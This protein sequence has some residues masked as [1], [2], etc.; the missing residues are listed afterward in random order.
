MRRFELVEGASNKFWEV[1][2]SGNDVTTHWGRIGTAG[3]SKTKTFASPA[4]AQKEHDD[5]VREK[6]AKGYHETGV[7][8][9]A[10]APV[11]KVP[12]PEPAA[13]PPPPP[14]PPEPKSDETIPRGELAR[15][16][17]PFRGFG[18]KRPDV[19]VAAAFERMRAHYRDH[20]TLWE[21]AAG[22]DPA[23]T[24]LLTRVREQLSGSSPALGTLEEETA[25]A[26]VLAFRQHWNLRPVDDDVIDRWVALGGIAFAVEAA[27]AAQ[28]LFAT[29]PPLRLERTFEP[30]LRDGYAHY[31]TRGTLGPLYRLRRHLASAPEPEWT[32]ARELARNARAAAPLSVRVAID[33]LFPEA[34]EWA[35]EDAAEVFAQGSDQRWRCALLMTGVDP[36]IA[37]RLIDSIGHPYNTIVCTTS[38]YGDVEGTAWSLVAAHGA[39]AAPALVKLFDKASDTSEWRRDI[40]A[41]LA[42]LPSDEALV[43]LASRL[44]LREVIPAATEAAHRFPR[45]AIPLLASLAGRGKPLVDTILSGV[46]A[47]NEAVV[48]ELLP[49]LSDSARALVENLRAKSATPAVEA[50]VDDLP[51]VL[52]NPPWKEKRK[53]AAESKPLQ[54][55]TF[56]VPV[57]VLWPPGLREEWSGGRS[58][59]DY[60]FTHHPAIDASVLERNGLTAVDASAVA[61]LDDAA[62]RAR[63]A[64]V[65]AA[66]QHSAYSQFY[67]SSLVYAS[68]K[69]ALAMWDAIPAERWSD[70]DPPTK[71]LLKFEARAFPTLLRYVAASP[72]KRLELLIPFRSPV[73]APLVADALAR[74]KSARAVAR[75]WL[76]L[77]P[78][79]AAIGLIPPAAGARGAARDA[80]ASALRFLTANG[81]EETV[82]STAARYGAEAAAAV[83]EA[84]DFDP[85]LLYP[86][87]LPKLPPFWHQGAFTR[88]LLRGNGAALPASAMETLATMLAFS[89]LGEPYAGLAE[90]KEACKPASLGAFAW[91]L[92]SA[93]LVAGAPSK[94]SW[95]FNAVGLLG[96]DACARRLAPLI[97]EWPGEAAHARAVAGLDVLA[98]IGSDVALMHLNGIAQKVKF[99]GLQEKAREKIEELAERRGLTAE[100]LADRLVP[101]LGLEPDGSMTLDFGPRSFRVGFDEHLRPYVKD[102]QGKKLPDLPKPGKS[103]DAEKGKQATERWKALK[104]DVKTLAGQQILRLETA[105][106]SRR[107]F[108]AAVFRQFFVEHPLVQHLVRRIVW[109]AYD[110]QGELLATF[111]VSEDRTFA[112]A[113]DDAYQLPAGAR[114]GVV[115]SYEITDDVA[116]AWGQLFGDYEI[117]QPWRQLGRE[118]YRPA[119][120]ERAAKKLTRWMGITLPTGKVLGLEQRGWRRSAAQDGGV[121]PWY[122][123]PLPSGHEAQLALDP[124]IIAGMALE[125]NEQTLGEVTI[126]KAG[127]WGGQGVMAFGELDPIVF[128]E[129]VRDLEALRP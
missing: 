92:F 75:R 31:F 13:A 12:K 98:A 46:M 34:A 65:A 104:K 2:V 114:V 94:E 83:R 24:P 28:G 82:M 87:R 115:H 30:E 53:A 9:T 110:D 109:G 105:M 127:D 95:A 129:I 88:P 79:T 118:V 107:R 116:A 32:A 81:H 42:L 69:L 26:A 72:G 111:R 25:V 78:E 27:T 33:Y 6:L 16:A 89:S 112:D 51:R 37:V 17:H 126:E 5:L 71:F 14:P 54:L 124:G 77:H 15:K 20:A 128:S 60:Y 122:L 45:R 22:Q 55:A 10:A 123:K 85:L 121:S 76:L 86:L 125:F 117:L 90:V 119:D 40:A 38:V 3:Q 62:L 84:L 106:C 102:A 57:E 73:A 103:D 91:D 66:N 7:A 58:W 44:D 39:L 120:G 36:A 113:N 1:E 67:P 97:R 29:N 64:E 43:A 49:A 70:Y 74:L 47:R 100:E 50:S 56:E 101:D 41:A 93:W 99:K 35:N 19:D 23:M 4:A 80:A 11:T 21:E 96:D 59:A 108:D 61:Q 52:G 63:I 18:L 8:T 68:E 48:N